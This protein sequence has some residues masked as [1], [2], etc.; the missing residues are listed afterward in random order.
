MRSFLK[1]GG[2]VFFVDSLQPSTAAARARPSGDEI[3]VRRLNDGREFR[4]VKVFYEP[5]SLAQRLGS[6]GWNADVR[7]T[8]SYFVHGSAAV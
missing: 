6:L 7:A 8:A 4:V 3:V 5:G 1:P 2:R